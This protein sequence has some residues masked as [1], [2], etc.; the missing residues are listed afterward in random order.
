MLFKVIVNWIRPHAGIPF[1]EFP[2]EAIDY[3]KTNYGTERISFEI[4]NSSDPI[5]LIVVRKATW[6]SEDAYNK[7]LADPVMME[8]DGR[9]AAYNRE[10]GIIVT[11]ETMILE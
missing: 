11:K 5:S 2:Q 10:N 1:Y 6:V 8:Y 3:C 7:C 9:A 4:E